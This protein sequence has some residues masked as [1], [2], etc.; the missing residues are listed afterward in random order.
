MMGRVVPMF[1]NNGIPGCCNPTIRVRIN[2]WN[3]IVVYA[4]EYNSIVIKWTNWKYDN[5]AK[6]DYI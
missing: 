3:S 1:S 2:I 6:S 4:N 5:M